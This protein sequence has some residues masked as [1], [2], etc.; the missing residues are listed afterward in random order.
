MLYYLPL[1]LL[2]NVNFQFLLCNRVHYLLAAASYYV[3][4]CYVCMYVAKVSAKK[5]K[6]TKTK[7]SPQHL[8]IPTSVVS[9]GKDARTVY[10]RFQAW[11]AGLI[12][13]QKYQLC[14]A[15]PTDKAT[16]VC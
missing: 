1:C 9:W 2:I 12:V 8:R 14:M 7:L 5:T 15:T 13:A 4:P 16:I 6:K 10:C 3:Y 11:V